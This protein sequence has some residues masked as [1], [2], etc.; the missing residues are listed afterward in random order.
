[1]FVE[2]RLPS[3]YE[4]DRAVSEGG[5]TRVMNRA[6]RTGRAFFVGC[7]TPNPTGFCLSLKVLA[8]RLGMG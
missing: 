5:W 3:P 8:S 7:Y 6:A 4:A 1:M 2:S